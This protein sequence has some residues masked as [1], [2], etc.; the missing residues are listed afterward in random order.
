MSA[1]GNKPI[2]EDMAKAPMGEYRPVES[3]LIK[4]TTGF[5]IPVSAMQQ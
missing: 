2:N 5:H 3:V 1:N 4:S